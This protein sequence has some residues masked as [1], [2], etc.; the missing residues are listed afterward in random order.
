MS[1]SMACIS[2]GVMAIYAGMGIPADYLLA[3]SIMAIPGGIVIAKIVYPET[4]TPETMKELLANID[5]ILP[6]FKK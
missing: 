3:A 6:E 5:S 2:V 1:G 4:E